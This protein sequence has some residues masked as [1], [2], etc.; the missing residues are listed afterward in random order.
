MF[1]SLNVLNFIYGTDDFI[2]D[3][4]TIKNHNCGKKC[5]RTYCLKRAI[6]LT[7]LHLLFLLFRELCQCNI[8]FNISYLIILRLLVSACIHQDLHNCGVAVA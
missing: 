7:Y 3:P 2:T 5:T 1:L 4:L 8:A 6:F